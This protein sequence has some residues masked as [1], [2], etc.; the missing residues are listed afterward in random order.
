[1]REY[2]SRVCIKQEKNV[3]K[4]LVWFLKFALIERRTRDF[5]IFPQS[6]ASIRVEKQEKFKSAQQKFT[7]ISKDHKR[8]QLENWVR[9]RRPWTSGIVFWRFSEKGLLD[10][11]R[12][13]IAFAWNRKRDN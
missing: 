3:W 10:K 9:S 2:V 11:A 12:K 13:A 4:F 1:M 8:S 6:T 7:S 5:L